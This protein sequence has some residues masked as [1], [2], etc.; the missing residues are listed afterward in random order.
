MLGRCKSKRVVTGLSLL[1]LAF[2]AVACIKRTQIIKVPKR[3][4]EAKSLTRSE[5]KTLLEKRGSEIRSLQASSL[6]ARFVG[7]DQE[8]GKMERY[9]GVPGY[10]IAE[11]PNLLRIT[12]QNPMTKSSL[13]D[14]VSDGSEVK[15]WIPR[16][17]K[18][19][20]GPIDMTQVIYPK[21]GENPLARIRPQHIFSALLFDTPN[22]DD[23]ARIFIE[24][25]SDDAAKY[26]VVGVTELGADGDLV[27]SRRIWIE[28]SESRVTR[29]RH[30]AQ[31]GKVIAEIFYRKYE[32]IDGIQVPVKVELQRRVEHY[33]MTLELD[34]IKVNPS[35]RA[36]AF[37]L[38]KIPSAE[39]VM[40]KDETLNPN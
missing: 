11:R 8:S 3:I 20:T 19:F 13:A 5:L 10:V 14:L 35:L 6:K 36:S 16:L 7:G 37:Q 33:S 27:L 28:R 23:W 21:A 25:D 40:L 32:I 26:Y 24:E 18:F 4:R 31:D 30:Y 1:W 12:L 2:G 29:E 34:R 17:N 15:I 39:L 22:T 38:K 9:M